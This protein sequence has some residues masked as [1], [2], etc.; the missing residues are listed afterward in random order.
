MLNGTR[1]V[2]LSRYIAGPF[3][4]TILGDLG[5][6]VIRIEQPGGAEDRDQEPATPNGD[7]LRYLMLGRNKKG[8]TLDY[9]QPRG[10][11]LLRRL[12]ETT[13]VLVENFSPPVSEK[14]GLTPEA[15]KEVKP[16]LIVVSV[17]GFGSTGPR[18]VHLG[19]DPVAQA[20]S[21]AMSFTGFPEGEP[22]R[23]QV[24][25]VD[26]STGL[27]AALGA[28]LALLH[29]TITGEGQSVEAALFDTAVSYVAFQGTA[30]EYQVLG[31]QRPRIGNAGYYV[32]IDTCAAKDGMVILAAI[33]SSQ[34]RRFAKVIGRPDLAQDD[35]LANDSLRYENRHIVVPI[36]QDW[37]R[38]LTVDE[39]LGAMEEA[40]IPCGRV[41]GVGEMVVNPQVLARELFQ[42]LDVPGAGMVPHPRLPLRLSRTSTVIDSPAPGVGEHN[43]QV[44]CG[45]LGMTQD[46]LAA[47]QAD[48]IV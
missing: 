12:L 2:D 45:T 28:V 26:L 23:G 10:M 17:S 9:S 19:F 47:L 30:A 7:N 38:T 18:R 46:E 21:G 15:L 1:V 44:Y 24:N 35:R 22:S 39:I 43:Q 5:A 32:Y 33:G 8:I 48:G 41:S 37:A 4:A 36:V 40:R 20:E 34:W 6:E 27:Y 16:D 25:W 11:D 13:D 42:Q 31:R 3:C 14:L 29:R